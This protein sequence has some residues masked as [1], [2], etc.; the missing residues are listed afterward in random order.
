MRRVNLECLSQILVLLL[1]DILLFY[2][3]VT[4]NI[5]Y[6]VHPRLEKYILFSAAV[7]PVIALSLL[8]GLFRPKRRVNLLPCLVLLVPLA[9]GFLIP[10]T[11]TGIANIQTGSTTAAQP[12]DSSPDFIRVSDED[13]MKWYTDA[14]DHPEKYD[15]K[16]IKI[17]GVVFRMDGFAANEFVPARMSMVCCAADMA[18]YG[19]ICRY[20]AA[21]ALKNDQWVYVTAKIKVEYELRMKKRMPILYAISVASA[22][23]PDKELVY[24]Y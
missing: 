14:C 6:Y 24:P 7:L 18:A 23:K 2:V 11:S 20:D 9:T 19:F 4:G 17:K 16:T 15:G 1:M 21:P 22:V 12:F 8:P 3:F 5:K 13:Y 10:A